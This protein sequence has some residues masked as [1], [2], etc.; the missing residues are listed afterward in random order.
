MKKIFILIVTSVILFACKKNKT[1]KWPENAKV[2][3][4]FRNSVQGKP[5]EYG[6]LLYTNSAGNLYSVT[7]LKYYISNVRFVDDQANEVK[8][9]NYDLIDAFDNTGKFN[10]LD[11]ATLP[12]ANYKSIRFYLGIDSNRN[13]N[14]AQDGD[15]DPMYN[16]IWSWNIGYL[17]MKHEGR[18]I[19][20]LGDTT[21][22]EYHFGTDL[23]YTE[24]MVPID[25]KI[26]GEDK[27]MF[28][29]FDLNDMYK[30]PPIDFNAKPIMHSL[31][32]N[33]KPTIFAMKINSQTAFKFGGTN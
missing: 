23:A 14:G 2:T 15:L 29:D 6:K 13:H 27:K 7:L 1:T 28:I 19:N 10:S 12:N 33:D 16:M 22:L 21:T 5:L 9:N 31:D 25:L 8:L 11:I 3:V 32:A 30:D 4:E 26:N 24:I 20:N 17:F 18:F